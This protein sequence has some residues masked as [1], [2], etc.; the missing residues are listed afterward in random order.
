MI[1]HQEKSWVKVTVENTLGNN[2]VG[3]RKLRLLPTAY[4][5]AGE[6]AEITLVT[7]NT[8]EGRVI[9]NNIEINGENNRRGD[10]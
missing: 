4:I 6:Y 5:D 10:I 2:V 1:L 3:T 7:D 9:Q 8:D